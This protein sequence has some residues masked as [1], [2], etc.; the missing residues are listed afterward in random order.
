MIQT[1][2]GEGIGVST[3]LTLD[4]Y[5][6]LGIPRGETL[7][8]SP[9][10]IFF[11]GR[12]ARD[13]LATNC[14]PNDNILCLPYA[15]YGTRLFKA[16]QFLE[17]EM[18]PR[19]EGL[20][21][22]GVEKYRYP[23]AVSTLIHPTKKIP[24]VLL[25][26]KAQFPQE[27][28]PKS[29]KLFYRRER[30]PTVRQ[31]ME[32][33]FFQLPGRT[34]VFNNPKLPGGDQIVLAFR[35]PE[36]QLIGGYPNADSYALRFTQDR[37]GRRLPEDLRQSCGELAIDF[38]A[39]HDGFIDGSSLAKQT[40]LWGDVTGMLSGL[41]SLHVDIGETL[42]VNDEYIKARPDLIDHAGYEQFRPELAQRLEVI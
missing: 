22:F 25:S 23:L 32:H 24:A 37:I 31:M 29:E 18:L 15:Y 19:I 35:L 3:G 4:A 36:S 27:E 12:V 33:G 2:G 10:T 30:I 16:D 13:W 41:D 5:K 8:F 9:P 14:G 6:A 7:Q 28:S 17:K 21:P 11:D 40:L 39:A 1:I 26:E 38:C 34:C 42:R 20:D